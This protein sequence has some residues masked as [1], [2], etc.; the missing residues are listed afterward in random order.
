MQPKSSA[1]KAASQIAESHQAAQVA[2]VKVHKRAQAQLPESR[3][4]P[5]LQDAEV[6]EIDPL[7][8]RKDP[9]VMSFV[10][11]A[12]ALTGAIRKLPDIHSAGS[13]HVLIF[14]LTNVNTKPL[15]LLGPQSAPPCS[16]PAARKPAPLLA[17]HRSA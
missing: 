11:Y 6:P 13:S 9:G 4:N 3:Q 2:L 5:F 10:D 16:R 15:K 8:L 1:E 7:Q 14:F 12:I 17:R